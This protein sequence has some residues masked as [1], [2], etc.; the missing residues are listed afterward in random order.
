MVLDD[1]HNT[2]GASGSHVHVR[3]INVRCTRRAGYGLIRELTWEA[4]KGPSTYVGAT[5]E[6]EKW[7]MLY[8][9]LFPL[10]TD[11]PSPCK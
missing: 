9:S 6:E 4:L 3:S 7:R 8:K 5:T 11:I 10:D 1:I 2:C